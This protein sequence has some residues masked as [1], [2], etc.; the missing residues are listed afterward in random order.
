MRDKIIRKVVVDP[1][2]RYAWIVIG[3]ERR[4]SW[5]V[6]RDYDYR[7]RINLLEDGSFV[8]LQSTSSSLGESD[9]VVRIIYLEHV[10]H[11]EEVHANTN[12]PAHLLTSLGRSMAQT[13]RFGI[14]EVNLEYLEA[15]QDSL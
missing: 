12:L 10:S 4:I 6:W 3:G 1:P 9:T 11:I 15:F 8:Y 2:E 13:S 14:P 5:E 7:H